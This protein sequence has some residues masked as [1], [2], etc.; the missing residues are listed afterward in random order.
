MV[1]LVLFG[2]L[3]AVLGLTVYLV[4]K[5]AAAQGRREDATSSVASGAS[6]HDRH[7]ER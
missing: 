5:N 6:S 4:G 3:G 7:A 1:T 2:F